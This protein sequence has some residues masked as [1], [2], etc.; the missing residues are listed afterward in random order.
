MADDDVCLLFGGVIDRGLMWKGACHLEWG[1]SE[2]FVLSV[3]YKP[4]K[5]IKQFNTFG[6][7]DAH[8]IQQSTLHRE[9]GS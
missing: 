3:R 4:N 2:Q 6:L 1:E 9:M 8:M 5:Q 7:Y